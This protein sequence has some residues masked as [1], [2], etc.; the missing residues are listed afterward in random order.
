MKANG[1]LVTDV[2]GNPVPAAE[3]PAG[4][5]HSFAPLLLTTAAGKGPTK[6]K[7]CRCR[8]A[9]LP[10]LPYEY[11]YGTAAIGPELVAPAARRPGKGKGPKP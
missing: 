6:S 2:D 7:D 1:D 3:L 9:T 5:Y 11:A 4:V 10:C 8:I